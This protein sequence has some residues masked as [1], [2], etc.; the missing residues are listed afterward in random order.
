MLMEVENKREEEGKN[1]MRNR[2]QKK[3]ELKSHKMNSFSR[4]LGFFMMTYAILLMVPVTFSLISSFKSLADFNDNMFGITSF[5]LEN[6]KKV[7][8]E[9]VYNVIM[10]DGSSGYYDFWGLTWNS[11]WFAIGR[12]FCSTM[13]P[14]IV[15]YCSAKFDFAIGK[16]LTSV[17]FITMAIPIIGTT[18]ASIEITR[19]LGLYDSIPG[20]WFLSANFLGATYLLYYGNFKSIPSD[21]TEAALVDG[22]NNFTIFF[23]IMLP[24]VKSLFTY[25]LIT[26]FMGE[27]SNYGIVLYYLPSKPTLSLAMMNFTSLSFTSVTMQMA[28]CIL[29]ALP[30][31]VLFVVFKDKFMENMQVGGIKG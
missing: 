19:A 13:V 28:G 9:F 4:I 2:K 20:T 6:Y 22:A 1:D 5:T 27:W 31:L 3:L 12:A 14:C 8:Q 11:F 7:M 16:I 24:M 15:A 25:H 30:C 26:G 29:L 23:R 21:Y 17:V 10:K 18:G